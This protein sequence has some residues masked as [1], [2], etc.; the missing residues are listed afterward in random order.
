MN[1]DHIFLDK[2]GDNW[3]SRNERELSFAHDSDKKDWIMFALQTYGI[4][5]K[6]VLE[7]GCSNGWRLDLIQ[8]KYGAECC[9]VEPSEKAI[10][11]GKSRYPSLKL[12]R[13]LAS[14]LP[15]KE[16]FDLVLAPFVFHWISREELLTSVA[17]V[18]RALSDGGLL[19]IT[20]FAPDSPQRVP[21]HHLPGENVYT[22]KIDYAGIFASTGMYYPVARFTFGHYQGKLEHNVESGKRS[23]CVL[24]RKSF[25]EFVQEEQRPSPRS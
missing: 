16:K 24:L 8:K 17:E 1:Q 6:K 25:S 15:V 20:D 22:Y 21:Y 12:Y 13:G 10:S 23:V 2:E 4:E 11:D 19:I 7:I 14:A 9:G 3:F 18:D 5:P